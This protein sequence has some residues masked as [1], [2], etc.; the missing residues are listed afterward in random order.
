MAMYRAPGAILFDGI[1]HMG[2]QAPTSSSESRSGSLKPKNAAKPA[3]SSSRPRSKL[4]TDNFDTKS[5]K[6]QEPSQTS[7]HQEDV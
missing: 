3:T 4:A 1:R 2:G 6:K 5:T 7:A